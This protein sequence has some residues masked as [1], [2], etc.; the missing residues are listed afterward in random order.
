MKRWNVS[1][2]DWTTHNYYLFIQD[3]KTRQNYMY[4]IGT[5]IIMKRKI[6]TSYDYV[7][8]R[9]LTEWISD[10]RMT[11][12]WSLFQKSNSINEP[13]VNNARTFKAMLVSLTKLITF[14]LTYKMTCDRH[15]NSHS[16]YIGIEIILII[17]YI[18]GMILIQLGINLLLLWKCTT[19]VFFYF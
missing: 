17:L 3:S 7:W 12:E 16:R 8:I 6:V 2:G 10:L 14:T 4:E 11:F 15:T 9:V 5:W 13:L 1:C 18:Y 19:F